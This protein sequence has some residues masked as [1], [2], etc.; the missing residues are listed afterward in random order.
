LSEN[1]IE[2]AGKFIHKS[3]GSLKKS[4]NIEL[5]KHNNKEGG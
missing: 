2:I 4:A 5:V 1:L 3:A